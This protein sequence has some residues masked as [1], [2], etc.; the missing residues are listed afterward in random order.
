MKSAIVHLLYYS[1]TIAEGLVIGRANV[2]IKKSVTTAQL[3]ILM[4]TKS[5]NST[6]NASTARVIIPHPPGNALSI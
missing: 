6:P 1:V 3:N 5:A 4:I 2:A